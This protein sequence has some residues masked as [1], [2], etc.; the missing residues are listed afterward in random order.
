MKT[1]AARRVLG[2]VRRRVPAPLR[3]RLV[4]LV[5]RVR[6]RGLIKV[7]IVAA[8]YNS[9]QAGLERLV[10]SLD[11]QSMPRR[12][13]EVIFVDDGS[14]DDTLERLSRFA[15]TRPN[16]VIHSIPNSGWSSRPRNVGIGMARGEYVLFMDHDDALFPEGLERAYAAGQQGGA[17]VVN[18]KEVRTRWWHWGWS[19]FARDRA[20]GQPGGPVPLLPMTPHKLYR[21]SFLDEHGIRFPEGRRVL[22]EDIDFN[23][24]CLAAKAKVAVLASYPFYHW[25]AT[26][27]NNSSTFTRI[28]E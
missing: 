10:R 16:Y 27:A 7:S 1:P 12:Q 3:T 6:D 17:D 8:A 22:W 15:A 20:P 28:G 5:R 9:D 18:A 2:Q 14:T 26:D 13:F 19:E 4:A 25:V 23:V 24:A 21:R 11:A